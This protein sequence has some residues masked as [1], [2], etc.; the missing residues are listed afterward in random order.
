MKL[1]VNGTKPHDGTL[2]ELDHERETIRLLSGEGEQMGTVS[3]RS[4]IDLILGLRAQNQP[5]GLRSELIG[6]LLVNVRYR[7]PDGQWFE[8]RPSGVGDEG[9]FI[10]INDPLPVGTKLM[11]EIALP[12]YPSEWMGAKGTVAWV[13]PKADQYAFSPGM[14]VRFAEISE[15]VRARLVDL[16]KS[17]NQA[18]QRV[19]SLIQAVGRPQSGYSDGSGSTYSLAPWHGQHTAHSL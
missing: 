3:W 9:L 5:E 11:M 18:R 19:E 16:V 4:V 12:D 7:T 14:G 1:P 17:F 13:C 6:S 2:L 10:E 15:E 8:G